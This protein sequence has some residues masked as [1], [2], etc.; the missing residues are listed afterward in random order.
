M[1]II[2]LIERVR[3][4][5]NEPKKKRKYNSKVKKQNWFLILL[6]AGLLLALIIKNNGSPDTE[7]KFNTVQQ[8]VND[9]SSQIKS[10]GGNVQSITKTLQSVQS[11]QQQQVQ[12]QSARRSASQRPVFYPVSTIGVEQWR[13][14]VAKYFPPNQVDNALK[15]MTLESGG[16][17]NSLSRT[18]DRGLMQINCNHANM[19]NYNLNALYDPET[20][21]RVAAEIFNSSYWYPWSTARRAGVI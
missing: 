2:T 9:L 11:T 19:V 18:C 17:P 13:G 6:I 15:I 14:L 10:L 7:R 4:K 3:R 12:L 5:L 8:E 21:I 20:N 16:N 1:M